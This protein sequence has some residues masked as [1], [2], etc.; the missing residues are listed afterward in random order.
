MF[1][2]RLLIA[3]PTL[4]DPNFERTVILMIEHGDEGALGV[5]LN[6][7]SGLAVDE[8]LPQWATLA[9]EPGVMFLGGPVQPNAVI[10]L[11]RTDDAAGGVVTETAVPGIGLVDLEGDPLDA[12]PDLTL[13]CF[14]GYAGWD[15]G[16]L[17]EE[18][19]QGAWFVVEP[20]IDDAF[21]GDAESLWRAVL[22]RQ[23]GDLSR[24]ALYP[25]DPSL[26]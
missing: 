13:R 8:V 21:S 17:E 11:G 14:A 16:Q 22:A 19:D 18:L 5:V 3:S 6:R 1:K 12:S 23:P 15:G 26:N 7:P 2:G 9:A 24:Y 25:K 20:E 10:C 4:G